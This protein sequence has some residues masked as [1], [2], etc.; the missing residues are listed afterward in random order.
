MALSRRRSNP[1]A[2][3]LELG[4]LLDPEW[5]AEAR[6]RDGRNPIIEL[7][8]NGRAVTQAFAKHALHDTLW[9]V[10]GL[11]TPTLGDALFSVHD[12]TSGELLAALITPGFRRARHIVGSVENREYPHVRGWVLDPRNPDR[13]R[14]VALHVNGLLHEVISINEQRSDLA[15]WKG[16]S[17]DHGFLWRLPDDLATKDGTLIDVF[18]AE[19]GRPLRGSPLRFV[20]GRL[21][22]SERPAR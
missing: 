13:R 12:G 21:I 15:R 16:T 18:D 6:Q 11:R 9:T 19:T 22:T 2:G 1:G 17:G 7:R 10:A 5:I 4:V 3:S 20:A 8:R 14:T